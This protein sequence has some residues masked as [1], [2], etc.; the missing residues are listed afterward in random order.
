MKNTHVI[1]WGKQRSL[2]M[3]EKR[4]IVWFSCGAASA[5]AAKIMAK[6]NPL[7]VYCN[8]RADEHRDNVRFMKDVEQWT[9]LKVKTIGS[10]DYATADDVVKRRDTWPASTVR[11]AQRS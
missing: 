10:K 6:H 1:R 9:G 4:I 3:F 8:T 5:C 11:G 7:L 2:G